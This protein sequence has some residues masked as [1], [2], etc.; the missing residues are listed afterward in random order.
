M[1]DRTAAHHDEIEI[2]AEERTH[3]LP[4]QTRAPF[5]RLPAPPRSVGEAVARARSALGAG[6]AKPAT[7]QLEIHHDGAVRRVAIER[8]V[9]HIGRGLAVDVRLDDQ[10][11]SRRH[12]VLVRGAQGTKLLDNRS[13]NGTWVNG[14]RVS[15]A[16][17]R[18]GDVLTLGRVMLRYDATSG[19]RVWRRPGGERRRASSTA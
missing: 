7:A 12:A 5:A 17:L 18:D 14:V 9:T 16:L 10:S 2:S 8:D 19:G 4:G 15:E 13:S 11:V 3:L 1:D 6:S